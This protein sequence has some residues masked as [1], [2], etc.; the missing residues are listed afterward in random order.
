MPTLVGISLAI[1]GGAI[2]Q[3]L[4]KSGLSTVTVSNLQSVFYSIEHQPKASLMIFGGLII[5]LAAMI[6]WVLT[7]KN[8]QLSK[9]YALLSLG[10]VVVYI[11]A[12]FWPNVLEPLSPQKSIGISLILFGV[13]YSQTEQTT[14][15]Q[16]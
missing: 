9:V 16:I 1:L 11:A 8:N 13:W 12:P 14:D 10:Y 6:I 5:Y 4:M 7:L 3:L 2:A 15:K